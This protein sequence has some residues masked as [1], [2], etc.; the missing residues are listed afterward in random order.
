MLGTCVWKVLQSFAISKFLRVTVL[1]FLFVS[2]SI[3]ITRLVSAINTTLDHK[4]KES[5]GATW[6]WKVHVNVP[7][8]FRSQSTRS[9]D[10]IHDKSRCLWWNKDVKYE[11]LSCIEKVDAWRKFKLH[12]VYIE[13]LDLWHRLTK[14]ITV[15]NNRSDVCTVEVR[16]HKSCW[17]NYTRVYYV[18]TV[19]TAKFIMQKYLK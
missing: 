15:I 8:P 2:N 14:M 5:P 13:D 9:K 4:H 18:M 1:A 16:Y 3:L 11:S 12:K 10:Q 7:V 17:E 19:K 6:I